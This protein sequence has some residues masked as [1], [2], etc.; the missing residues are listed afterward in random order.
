MCLPYLSNTFDLQLET[1][2]FGINAAT[3]GAKQRFWRELRSL[4][5]VTTAFAR[6]TEQH[7]RDSRIIRRESCMAVPVILLRSAARK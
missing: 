3:Y 5:R 2:G 6:E 1:K 7:R 4:R